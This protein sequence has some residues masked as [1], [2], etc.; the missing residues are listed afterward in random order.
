[1]REGEKISNEYYEQLPKSYILAMR[2]LQE[3]INQREKEISK[4]KV[5]IKEFTKK[6]EESEGEKER[7]A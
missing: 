6:H 4:L 1:M 5:T 7:Y 3:V 2:G